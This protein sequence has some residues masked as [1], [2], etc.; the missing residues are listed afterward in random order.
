MKILFICTYYHRA[1]IFHDLAKRIKDKGHEVETFNAVVKKAKIYEK[2]KKIMEDSD[3]I[4][5]ECFYYWDRYFYFIKQKK[6]YNALIKSCEVKK[7]DLIHSHNLFNGGYVAYN[8]KRNFGIPY[9]VSIRST[10]VNSFLRLPLFKRIANKILEE[11]SGIHFLSFPYKENFLQKFIIKERLEIVE[12]K[13]I[14]ITNGLEDFWL[15]NRNNKAKEI[16]NPKKVRLLLVGK[17]NK[18]KNI[19]SVI[20]AVRLLEQKDYK[21]ELTVVGQIL[22]EK[23]LN[24]I[25]K[26]KFITILPYKKKEELLKIYRENDIFVMP[27]VNETF[28][29]VYAE[30]MTQGLPVI[31]SKGQGFDRI[32]EDGW[33]GYS[34]PS[35]N[36]VYISECIIKII[37]NFSAI[38]KKCLENCNRF[39][40]RKISEDYAKF[41][42]ESINRK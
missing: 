15:E 18:N 42:K 11:A 39:N 40:W 1:M 36:I 32:F 17:I 34:V 9:I 38:S 21:I 5:K 2:Y 6:I 10:D 13:S 20:E 22:D 37:N 41:Y 3:V 25:R 26:E 33:I 19:F 14:V 16:K 23:V 28:G 12:R 4:H 7:Y 35:N 24:K 31:Y 8:L 30:A 29:R 27:S